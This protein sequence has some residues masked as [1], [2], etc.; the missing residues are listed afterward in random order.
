MDRR[1][2]QDN[3]GERYVMIKAMNVKRSIDFRR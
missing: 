2:P 3:A 1:Y